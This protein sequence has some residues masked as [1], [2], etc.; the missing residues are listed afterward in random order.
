[1]DAELAALG[2]PAELRKEVFR[3]IDR[4]DKMPAKEWEAYATR[5]WSDQQVR[6]K[7]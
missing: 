5:A 6:S 2:I 3:L 7:V 1:M 4:R